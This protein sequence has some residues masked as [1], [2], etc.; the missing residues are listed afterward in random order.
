MLG[1]RRPL[2]R[3]AVIGGGAYAIGK[4]RQAGKDEAAAQSDQAAPTQETAPPQ[5][6][7]PAP[8][9]VATAPAAA[10]GDTIA[11]LKQLKG[12]LDDGVLTQAE[13]DAEKTKLLNA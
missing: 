2:M 3:A 1:R 4:R 13:F 11:Q 9:P 5:E 12:L 10:E 6:A 7:A 8:A